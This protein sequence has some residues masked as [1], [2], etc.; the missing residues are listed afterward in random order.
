[1]PACFKI[2]WEIWRTELQQEMMFIAPYTIYVTLD[3]NNLYLH[4]LGTHERGEELQLRAGQLSVRIQG[5]QRDGGRRRAA[6][7]HPEE[8][9]HQQQH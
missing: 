8:D 2:V 9:E 5:P 7:V 1:M 4:L 3:H 6:K